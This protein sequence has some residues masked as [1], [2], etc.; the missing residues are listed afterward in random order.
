MIKIECENCG[1]VVDVKIPDWIESAAEYDV[2][3]CVF[4]GDSEIII[5][6]EEK[7]NE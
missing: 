7:T 5:T 4:C 3:H 1:G 6:I 2:S